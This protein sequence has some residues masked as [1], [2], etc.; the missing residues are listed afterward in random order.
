MGPHTPLKVADAPSAQVRPLGQLLLLPSNHLDL[1]DHLSIHRYWVHGGPE[2][3]FSAADYYALLAEAEATEGFIARTA[4]IMSRLRA[5]R[6]A[7]ASASWPQ[8]S[9][10]QSSST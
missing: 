1:L 6:R 9:I 5:E 10:C 4:A 7:T 3:R 8:C 2:T